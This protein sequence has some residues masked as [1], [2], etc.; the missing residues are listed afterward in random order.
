MY[1]T[2]VHLPNSSESL[3]PAHT[4]SQTPPNTP[5]QKPTSP[6]SR[7]QAKNLLNLTF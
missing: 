7:I 1:I 5:K 6:I 3:P 2:L 4:Y